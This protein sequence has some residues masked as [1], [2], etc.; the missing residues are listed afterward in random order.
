M[1]LSAASVLIANNQGRLGKK[2][3]TDSKDGELIKLTC[4][5]NGKEEATGISDIIE[6]KLKKKYSLNK[7]ILLI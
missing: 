6:T 3:W 2:L 5:K 1:I 4:Y 7:I